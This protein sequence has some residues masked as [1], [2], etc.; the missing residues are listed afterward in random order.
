VL[1]SS[2]T[3]WE[4]EIKRARGRLRTPDDVVGMIDHAGFE[5]LPIDFEHAV[6]AGR[7]P[8]LHGDPFDRMLVAQAQVE[9]LMLATGDAMLGRYDVAVLQV[10][11]A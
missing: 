10:T 2:A 1:V 4:I 11:R 6:R 5:P 3:I 8:R 7:L 9:G